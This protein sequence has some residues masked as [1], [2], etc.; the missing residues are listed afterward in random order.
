MKRKHE[1]NGFHEKRKIMADVELGESTLSMAYAAAIFT[2]SLLR[3]LLRALV[4]KEAEEVVKKNDD[5]DNVV[6]DEDDEK[7]MR[8]DDNDIGDIDGFNDDVVGIED[9]VNVVDN[10]F[11][12]DGDND[13]GGGKSKDV[14]HIY[15][16]LKTSV[17]VEERI[18]LRNDDLDE[19]YFEKEATMTQNNV[20]PWVKHLS[21]SVKE[22]N[23][24]RI[25]L[26]DDNLDESCLEKLNLE[27]EHLREIMRAFIHKAIEESLQKTDE[28]N[29]LLLQDFSRLQE[30]YACQ[31]L[32]MTALI[33][34][35][36]NSKKGIDPHRLF[37]S[38][39]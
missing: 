2:D 5:D 3:A 17:E 16:E 4:I 26:C 30:L 7:I 12:D 1:E 36:L 27:F 19:E 9:C 34:K 28:M 31:Y 13:G 38:S 24:E 11:I 25:Q 22:L 29:E 18:Q 32:L 37:Q 14:K 6:G 21:V 15:G 39:F 23:R 35:R 20:K 33:E 8:F 10:S